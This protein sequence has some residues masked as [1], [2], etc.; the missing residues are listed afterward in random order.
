MNADA[1]TPSPVVLAHAGRLLEKARADTADLRLRAR[2]LRA[3]TDWHA[4]AAENYRAALDE[5]C[6]RFDRVARLLEAADDEVEA[7]HRVSIAGASCR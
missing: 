5:L 1:C 2:A 4:R 6:A 7:L 3:D